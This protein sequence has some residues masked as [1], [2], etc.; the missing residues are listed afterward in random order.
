MRILRLFIVAAAFIVGLVSTSLAQESAPPDDAILILD[1]S[2]SMWG[3]IDGVNKIVIAK[4]VVEGLVRGLPENQRLGMVAYGHR[5]KGDCNDIETLA[6]VGADRDDVIAQIRALSP[7][8]K[9]PL[10]K[11]VEHAATELNYTEN[12]ATVILVSDGLET[13][14]ADPCALARTLEENGL[15]F[16][17]HV[18]GFDVTEEERQGLQCIAEET[19][20]EFLAADNADE[21][22]AALT[23]VAM[24]GG[25]SSDASG[26]VRPQTVAL[27]A[28]MMQNGPDIQSKLNWKVTDSATGETVF[29]RDNTGYVDFEVVPGEYVAEAIWT[30][31]PHTS[32]RYKGDKTGS[33]AFTIAAAPTVVTVPIDLDI[34]VT[35]EADREIAE[36]NPINIKWSGPDDLGAYVLV[37][38][39]DDGPREQIYFTIA[40]RSRDAY[41]AK[42][43][44]EGQGAVDLD[45]N[46]DGTFNQDD[47]AENE[48]GGPSIEGEYEV[49][50]VLSD[51]RLILARL[52]LTVSDSGYTVSAPQE[53]PAASKFT[54]DWTGPMTAGDFVTIEEADLKTAF[55]PFGGRPRLEQGVPMELVAPAEP[56]DYEIRYVLANGYT[57]Y[58]GMQ[59]AVQARQP[60]K[61]T[62]VSADAQAPAEIVG[63]SMVTVELTH[64]PGESWQDDYLSLVTPGATKYNR[65]SWGSLKGSEDG[66]QT[67]QFQAPNIDGDYELVYF[68]APGDKPLSRNPVKVTRAQASV[69]APETVKAG[70]DFTVSYTGPR[71]RGDRIIVAPASVE[72]AKMWGWSS[73]YGFFVK[74]GETEGT[75]R[76]G[77]KAT[78]EP[79]EYVVRYVTGHQHQTLARD[80]LTVTE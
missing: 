54:V 75:V 15:D 78:K 9:T 59:H 50:Y 67:L 42:A 3:Q 36:G 10:T 21:L 49:R 12:A 24:A 4:D 62:A 45:T 1:A 30:G 38:R 60:I 47:I 65:D 33:K 68:L 55:T 58:E 41:Q 18:V 5:K 40:Q 14:E 77:F 27:K 56:G 25:E 51:P 26:D 80:T 8:G 57:T 28:T 13:C 70:T 46:G 22:N 43:E 69:D 53:V 31:W 7:V 37:S 32:D 52:P 61:V 23:Q 79:G 39:L 34:P 66:G 72:D 2:G 20:G 48:I 73:N 74:E 44:K 17:V 6:D 63:G 35:L 76:G 11:S 71:Y 19:G 64:V 29:A 16:T